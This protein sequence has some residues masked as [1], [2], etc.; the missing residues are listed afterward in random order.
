MTRIYGLLGHGISYS[1]SPAMQNAAFKKAGIDAEYRIFD[2]AP[3]GV[4]AFF[5]NILRS[6]V[7]GLNVTV[8]YKVRAHDFIKTYGH[9]D[10]AADMLGAVNTIAIKRKSLFG[11]NTDAYGFTRSLWTDLK[12]DPSLKNVLI[13]GMGGAGAACAMEIAKTAGRVFVYDIDKKK[14]DIF[15]ERFLKFFPEEKLSRIND[16]RDGMKEALSQ[17]S[18]LVNA[19]PFGRNQDELLIDGSFFHEELKVYD[20]IYNPPETPLVKEARKAGLK[21]AGGTGMLLYQGA[22]SFRIWTG[23]RAPVRVMKD[24]LMNALGR[25]G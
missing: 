21:A 3:D 15:A 23:R 11:Y 5:R 7:S 14:T 22:K 17:C 10:E 25:A 16:A 1:L 2:T 4:D 20:L 6:G 13:C 18:L 12:F 24:A 8:P 9:V 19:T